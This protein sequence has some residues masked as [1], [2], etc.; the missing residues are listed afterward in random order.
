MSHDITRSMFDT[1]LDKFHD[2]RMV[3]FQRKTDALIDVEHGMAPQIRHEHHI[4]GLLYALQRPL[5]LLCVCIIEE[6]ERKK[7]DLEVWVVF[8]KPGVCVFAAVDG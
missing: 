6:R 4:A 3:S 5:V 1:D 7:A 2:A 8:S